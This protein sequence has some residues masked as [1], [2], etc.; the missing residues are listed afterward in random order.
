MKAE[1]VS[2]LEDFIKK[3]VGAQYIIPV[4]QRNYNW[5]KDDQIKKLLTDVDA[6][7][8]DTSKKHF[9]GSVVYVVTKDSLIGQERAVVDGQQRLT[10]VFLMLYAL[11]DLAKEAGQIMIANSITTLYLENINTDEKYKLRLKPSVSDDDTFEAIAK[12]DIIDVEEKSRV[13]LNYQFIKSHFKD[14]LLSTD[15]ENVVNALRRLYIVYIMLD[16]QDDAQQIFESINSTGMEL[17]AADLI[18][19]YILMNK[20]NDRQE[21]L[22]QDIWRKLETIFS[23][24]KKLEGF[25]R[26]YLASKRQVF[27]NQS[28]LY[29]QFQMYWIESRRSISEDDLLT[30]IL[31]YARHFKRLYYSQNADTLGND[32]TDFRRMKSEM[33]A[34]FVLELF[35]LRRKD[36]IDDNQVKQTL[37]LINTYL[38]R[39]YIVGQDTSDITRFFPTFLKNVL[40]TTKKHGFINFVDICKQHL[41]KDTRQKSSYM[42]D[43]DQIRTYLMTTNSYTFKHMRWLLEKVEMKNN[44]VGINFEDLSIEHVL[45]QTRSHDWNEVSSVEDEKYY[46][47]VHRI[48]NLTLVAYSDNSKMGNKSFTFKK[49]ILNETAHIKMNQ[50]ILGFDKWGIEEIVHNAF[51][52]SHERAVMSATCAGH[53]EPSARRSGAT[54]L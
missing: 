38:I 17:T 14:L 8:K 26:F 45:P 52:E 33:P 53:L 13:F 30:D 25:F 41:I 50:Y 32:L 39:R 12:G 23:D 11:R 2:F 35:E 46:D 10:T 47:Y 15:I 44:P 49:Q 5:K 28:R 29:Q 24:S 20:D 37:K 18:R 51:P 21:K 27:T 48:G 54:S 1:A 4:Y 7:M 16:F 34:P 43:D 36:L 6:L 19:N 40:D 31:N 22:Y 42:P 9:I 3:S